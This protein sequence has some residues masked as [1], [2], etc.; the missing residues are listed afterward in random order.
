LTSPKN[1]FIVAT[2]R[3]T[4]LHILVIDHKT[5]SSLRVEDPPRRERAGVS[6]PTRASP[7]PVRG[8]EVRL[9]GIEPAHVVTEILA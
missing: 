4:M 7:Y 9:T 3:A 1:R 2:S 8:L 6:V 5:P